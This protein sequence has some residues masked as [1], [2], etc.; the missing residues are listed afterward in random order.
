[1]NC[2]ITFSSDVLQRNNI[3]FYIVSWTRR[4]V[5]M[6]FHI[7]AL[8]IYIISLTKSISIYLVPIFLLKFFLQIVIQALFKE[9]TM[10]LYCLLNPKEFFHGVLH[11]ILNF[12]HQ[13]LDKINF[14]YTCSNYFIT[15]S[16]KD[17]YSSICQRNYILFN[18]VSWTKRS[19][20]MV[21]H[22][23]SLIFHINFLK[24]TISSIPVPIIYN[25]FL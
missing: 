24:K 21:Y 14:K 23:W 18:S 15:F 10:F 7:W 13:P 6:L 2:F 17:Y 16:S 1:M 11:L 8:I 22:I 5:S 3:L 20:S 19:V 4:S 25:I 12:S 9:I